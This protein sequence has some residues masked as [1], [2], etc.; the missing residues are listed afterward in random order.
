MNL[1]S[2]QIIVVGPKQAKVSPNLDNIAV[3]V[4]YVPDI[5]HH[6]ALTAAACLSKPIT[7][8]GASKLFVPVDVMPLIQN[9][10]S[11][12]IPIRF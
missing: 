3:A 5:T 8:V 7:G 6:L 11:H 10:I 2:G 4:S 1:H 12:G 9:S